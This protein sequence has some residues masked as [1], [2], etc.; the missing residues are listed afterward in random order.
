MIYLYTKPEV[1]KKKN[2]RTM[3]I[4]ETINEACIEEGIFLVQDFFFFAAA[5]QD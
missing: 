4:N 2:T 5:G 1:K 3:T